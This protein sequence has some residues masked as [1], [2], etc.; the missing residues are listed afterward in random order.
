[1]AAFEFQ[2]YCFVFVILSPPL[3]VIRFHGVINLYYKMGV[4]AVKGPSEDIN[5][6]ILRGKVVRNVIY[7]D[8]IKSLMK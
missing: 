6:P 5:Q 2:L 8:L 7:L 1:M 3:K 4:A